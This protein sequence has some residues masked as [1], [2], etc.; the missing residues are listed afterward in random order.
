LYLEKVPSANSGPPWEMR[1]DRKIPRY[2]SG[3]FVAERGFIER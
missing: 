3:D 1:I 2:F